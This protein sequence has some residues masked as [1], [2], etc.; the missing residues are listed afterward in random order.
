MAKSFMFPSYTAA[1][2]GA[3]V[4]KATDF[5]PGLVSFGP[6]DLS[7]GGESHKVPSTASVPGRRFSSCMLCC[8]LCP[9][10]PLLLR[11]SYLRRSRG[12]QPPPS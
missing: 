7:P 8:S 10:L 6:T 3:V 12:E 9:F 4:G 11:M 2:L 1:H 5:S